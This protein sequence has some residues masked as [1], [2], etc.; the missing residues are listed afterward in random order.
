MYNKNHINTEILTSPKF[1]INIYKMQI[2][3]IF[4]KYIKLRYKLFLI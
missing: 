4:R 1:K 3:L 2:K